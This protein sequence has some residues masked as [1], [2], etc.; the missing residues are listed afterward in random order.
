MSSSQDLPE[1]SHGTVLAAFK[2]LA[3]ASSLL[4]AGQLGTISTLLPSLY[5]AAQT[6][7]RLAARQFAAQY[8]T[9]K[10]TGPPVE[11]L[12]TIICSGLAYA[13]YQH[14]RGALGWKLWAGAAVAIFSAI[15]WTIALMETPSTK[16]LWVSEVAETATTTAGRRTSGVGVRVIEPSPDRSGNLAGGM[17]GV[18]ASKGGAKQGAITPMEDFEPFEDAPMDE[19]EYVQ[20]K[21]INLLKQFNGLNVVRTLGPLTAGILGLWAS[22]TE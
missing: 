21:V 3:I 12:T 15:P 11:L 20:L 19:R 10:A 13:G 6:S 22:L 16:L 9:I 5:P 8:R 14:N 1:P 4:T 18:P 2:G 7:H 17:L